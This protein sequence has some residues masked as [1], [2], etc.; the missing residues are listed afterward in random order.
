MVEAPPVLLFRMHRHGDNQR[1]HCG[2]GKRFQAVRQ[3]QT[4]PAGYGLHTLV[5]KQMDQGAKLTMVFAVGN[6]FDKGGRG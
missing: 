1:R 4:Q 6:R 3:E 2:P 5:L